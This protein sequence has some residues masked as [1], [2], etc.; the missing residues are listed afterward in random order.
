MEVLRLRVNGESSSNSLEESSFNA[1]SAIK[2]VPSLSEK[3]VVDFFFPLKKWLG[4]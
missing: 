4:P 1:V 3:E 2:L